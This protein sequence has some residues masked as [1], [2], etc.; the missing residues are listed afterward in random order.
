MASQ[1]PIYGLV[2]VVNVIRWSQVSTDY[3]AV[4]QGDPTNVYSRMKCRFTTLTGPTDPD[5]AYVT[6]RDAA[7][8]HRVIMK[9]APDIAYDDFISLDYGDSAGIGEGE[10][11]LVPHGDYRIFYIK[12]EIDHWGKPHHT[13]VLVEKE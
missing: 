3:G 13:R 2:S 12:H 8:V 10:L 1:L 5:S 6:G 7:K 9:Y 4:V 11:P